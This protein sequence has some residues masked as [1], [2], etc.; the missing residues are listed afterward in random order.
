MFQLSSMMRKAS[1]GLS[2]VTLVTAG[3]LAIP[4]SISADANTTAV[5]NKPV[6]LYA[7]EPQART[8][9]AVTLMAATHSALVSGQSLS[10][11]N[12]TT[13]QIINTITSGTTVS[14]TITHHKATS[15]QFAA[16]LSTQSAPLTVSWVDRPI[17][18]NA[19]YANAAGQTVALHTSSQAAATLPLVVSAS[20]SG[21]TSPVYQFWWAMQGG[22]WH[23]SG[24]FAS[25]S[26][27]SIIPPRNGFLSVVV[28]AREALSPSHETSAQQA[29]YEA[30]SNTAVVTVGPP[31]DLGGSG[32]SV[33]QNGWVS[34]TTANQI[35]VGSNMSLNAQV[36]G[37]TTPIYQFWFESPQGGWQSSGA[38]STNPNFAISAVTPGTWHVV[39]YARPKSAPPNETTAQRSQLEVQSPV[40]TVTVHP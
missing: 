31:V 8:G 30:K 13:N 28:Y 26:T 17:G 32:S 25:K 1:T 37:I 33:S 40:T 9:Q 19:G 14:T 16:I 38:Y 2:V 6:A 18:N 21:F 35:A 34:L 3:F 39:V 15:Q 22:S 12:V 23:N 27:V 4:A 20:P 36:S 10:I 24:S 29:Q 5:T 11:I 7:T